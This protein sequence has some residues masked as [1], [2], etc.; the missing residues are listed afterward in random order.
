MFTG[1]ER[2][3]TWIA[4]VS[5]VAM[6]IVLG[7]DNIV[8]IS[9]LTAR[10]PEAQRRKVT[11]LG[12]GLAVVMRIGLLFAISWVLGLTRPSSPCWASP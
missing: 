7:V 1:I 5:L 4:L 9:V 11:H 10:L 6:E 8:F 12:I 2:A 3:D